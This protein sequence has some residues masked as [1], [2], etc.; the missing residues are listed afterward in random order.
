M[1]LLLDIIL[2][3]IITIELKT[4]I[5]PSLSNNISNWKRFVEDKVGYL[6]PL[7][8]NMSWENQTIYK[9]VKFTYEH[10]REK[11]TI[12]RC[13]IDYNWKQY[14]KNGRKKTN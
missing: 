2:P 12:F 9:N 6:Q 11:I 8:V 7:K 4:K 13:F 3:R 1:K 10:D 14:W 5:A